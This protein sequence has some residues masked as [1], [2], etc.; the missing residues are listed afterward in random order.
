MYT[1]VSPL[2]LRPRQP[3][4]TPYPSWTDEH[5]RTT[6]AQG[7]GQTSEAGEHGFGGLRAGGGAG[8]RGVGHPRHPDEELD[9]PLRGAHCQVPYNRT[10]GFGYGQGEGFVL[11]LGIT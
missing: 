4:Q 5:I 6:T 8:G 2:P 10:S 1:G 3:C 9:L 11:G 7:G